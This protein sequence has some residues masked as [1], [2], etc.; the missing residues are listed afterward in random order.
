MA[1]EFNHVNLSLHEIAINFDDGRVTSK[2]LHT[3]KGPHSSGK[4]SL[5][6]VT[7]ENTNALR[8]CHISIDGILG[9]FSA[10]APEDIRSI[11]NWI[12]AQVA[13]ASILLIKLY[14]AASAPESDMKKDI[15]CDDM[16][17]GQRITTII[18]LLRASAEDGKSRPAHNFSLVMAMLHVWYEKQ[19][20]DRAISSGAPVADAPE[21]KRQNDDLLGPPTEPKQEENHQHSRG[22]STMDQTPLHLLSE[23]AMGNSGSSGHQIPNGGD[24][25]HDLSLALASPGNA[26]QVDSHSRSMVGN[27]LRRMHPGFMQALGMTLATGDLNNMEDD[28]FFDLM[29]K[30]SNM[31]ETNG[32]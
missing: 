7:S 30:T 23:V 2:G 32:G 12:F 21:Q 6:D 5:E 20:N 13:Y 31:F 16:N 24:S 9:S 18:D 10:F 17:V 1:L 3:Q 19:I 25:T 8:I 15:P 4:K 26:P 14:F 28:G 27:G 11:P 29:Q 22:P